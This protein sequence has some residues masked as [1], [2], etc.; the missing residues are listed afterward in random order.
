MLLTLKSSLFF[1]CCREQPQ[2]RGRAK[3]VGKE[4]V[5]NIACRRRDA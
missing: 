5:T 4:E 2:G 1:Q 3:S